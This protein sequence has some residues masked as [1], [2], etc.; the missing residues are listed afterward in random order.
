MSQT[1]WLVVGAGVVTG[2]IVA[3]FAWPTPAAAPH[4]APL[5]LLGVG[6]AMALI[7]RLRYRNRN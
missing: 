3:V 6:V 1:N 4:T 2:M 7:A 5:V